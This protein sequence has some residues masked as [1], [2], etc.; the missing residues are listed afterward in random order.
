MSDQLHIGV[1][2]DIAFPLSS[3]IKC[4]FLCFASYTAH[5]GAVF[6]FKACFYGGQ[7]PKGGGDGA[8][9]CSG[10]IVVEEEQESPAYTKGSREL[11]GE[12]NEVEG[13]FENVAAGKDALKMR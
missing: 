11:R 10:H 9:N 5:T 8:K 6:A 2:E 1:G 13:G 12:E 7:A 3:V 4:D